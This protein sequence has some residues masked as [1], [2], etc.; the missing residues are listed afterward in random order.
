MDKRVLTV[1]TYVITGA[2]AVAVVVGMIDRRYTMPLSLQAAF[3]G[4]VGF[5]YTRKTLKNGKDDK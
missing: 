5:L 1:V 2:W 4:V 3:A